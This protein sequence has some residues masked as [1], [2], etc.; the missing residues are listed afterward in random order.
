MAFPDRRQPS[1]PNF[2]AVCHRIKNKAI[3]VEATIP[4]LTQDINTDTEKG[5]ELLKKTIEEIR[6]C[7]AD[8]NQKAADERAF[9]FFLNLHQSRVCA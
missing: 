9:S 4:N 1:H 7:G 8:A 3:D 5:K 2:G 6:K